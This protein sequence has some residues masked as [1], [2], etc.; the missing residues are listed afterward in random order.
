MLPPVLGSPPSSRGT[1]ELQGGMAVIAL[2]ISVVPTPKK[3]FLTRNGGCVVQG[4]YGSFL[5]LLFPFGRP[6]G[7]KS[8]NRQEKVLT[9]REKAAGGNEDDGIDV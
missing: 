4:V 3:V 1:T 6:Q 7:G 9:G 5:F 8:T 2:G